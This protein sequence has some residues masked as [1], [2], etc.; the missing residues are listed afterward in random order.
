MQ[1]TEIEQ[2]I[3]NEPWKT[4]PGPGL[5]AWAQMCSHRS[6]AEHACRALP[7]WAR[8]LQGSGHSLAVVFGS[9]FWNSGWPEK[10]SD[11]WDSSVV[12][13]ASVLDSIFLIG[14]FLGKPIQY[15]VDLHISLL[16]VISFR[17]NFAYV[18]KLCY[19]SF[20]HLS[21][22]PF[23]FLLPPLLKCSR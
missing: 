8:C 10:S 15:I 20:L 1:C 6:L 23:L 22:S 5:A 18:L 13:Q 9:R 2:D 19:L 3:V 14:W 17:N 11:T 12:P 7:G 4:N 16:I 21:F